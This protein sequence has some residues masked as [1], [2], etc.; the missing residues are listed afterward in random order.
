MGKTGLRHWG[1]LMPCCLFQRKTLTERET[2]VCHRTAICGIR[3]VA[4]D[5]IDVIIVN[6]GGWIIMGHEHVRST[7]PYIYFRVIYFNCP[8]KLKPS[9]REFQATAHNVYFV[10]KDGGNCA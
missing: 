7:C 10:V 3:M 9:V 4:A 5:Y 8:E 2:R 1:K 6:Y